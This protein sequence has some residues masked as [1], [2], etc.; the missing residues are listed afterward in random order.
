MKAFKTVTIDIEDYGSVEVPFNLE[1]LQTVEETIKEA[2]AADWF[3]FGK[4]KRMT[5]IFIKFT[6]KYLPDFDY[7]KADPTFPAFFFM[8]VRNELHRSIQEWVNAMESIPDFTSPT[9]NPKNQSQE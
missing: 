4:K 6:K 5:D 1:L 7:E 9:E 8:S 3:P 2:S